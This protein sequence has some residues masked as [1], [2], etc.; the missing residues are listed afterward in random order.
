MVFLDTGVTTYALH[1]GVVYTEAARNLAWYL[2]AAVHVFAPFFKDAE[3][4]AQTSVYCAVEERLQH[5]S[6]FYYSD[7]ARKELNDTAKSVES[8]KKLWE[9]SEEMVKLPKPSDT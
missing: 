1:P 2:R 7:C 6:G 4:G 8:A 5:E 9:I 3:H